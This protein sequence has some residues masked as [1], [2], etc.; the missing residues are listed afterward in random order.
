MLVLVLLTKQQFS[1][2]ILNHHRQSLTKKIK[3]KKNLTNMYGVGVRL[4][5]LT[6]K[7]Y[8]ILLLNLI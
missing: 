5:M 2:P 8:L 4:S 6:N 1:I 3:T 7:N